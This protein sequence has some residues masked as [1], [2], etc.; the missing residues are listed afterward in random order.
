MY[1]IFIEFEKGQY[2][3]T[4]EYNVKS[5]DLKTVLDFCERKDYEVVGIKPTN[6]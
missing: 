6:K 1:K 4:A 2:F 5:K 3:H